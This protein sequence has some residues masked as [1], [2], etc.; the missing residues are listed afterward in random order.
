MRNDAAKE[1]ADEL[2]T[3]LNIYT[4][5][6][7]LVPTIKQVTASPFGDTYFLLDKSRS[8]SASS[9]VINPD[10]EDPELYEQRARLQAELDDLSSRT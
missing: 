4:G 2:E 8:A 7:V 5:T 1:L 10:A 6:N 3:L 9:S